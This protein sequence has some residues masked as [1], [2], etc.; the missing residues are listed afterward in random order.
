MTTTQYSTDRYSGAVH[1][2]ETERAPLSARTADLRLMHGV[3]SAHPSP[4]VLHAPA[5]QPLHAPVFH[6]LHE[7]D[8]LRA[9]VHCAGP[10]GL[11]HGCAPQPAA[12]ARA[13]LS[14]WHLPAY[15]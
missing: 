15:P 2:V 3:G 4:A 13:P 8:K 5:F 11:F 1:L 14:G 9:F 12:P 7:W 6:A 10:L